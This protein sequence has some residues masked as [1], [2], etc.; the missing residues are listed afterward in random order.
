MSRRVIVIGAGVIGLH[1]A[2][3]CLRRGH[4]VD[5]IERGGPE[6]S[7]C[8]YGNAGMIVPSHFVTLAAPG[9]VALGLRWMWNPKSPFYIKPRLD[10]DLFTWAARFWRSCTAAHVQR[11]GPLLCDLHLASSAAYA[12]L[13]DD[14]ND[15]GL[16]QKGLLMLCKRQQTLDEEKETDVLL[17]DI[18]ENKINYQA[19]REED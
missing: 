8:S 3:E 13:S 12:K 18:A 10:W 11:A 15:I 7:G 9:M 2:V 1:C 5:I 4:K 16:V 17:T 14:G 6:R 19:A